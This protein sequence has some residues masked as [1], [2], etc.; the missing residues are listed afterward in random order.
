MLNVRSLGKT[1]KETQNGICDPHY[2]D[3]M[4]G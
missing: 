4:S 2:V 3:L 1:V